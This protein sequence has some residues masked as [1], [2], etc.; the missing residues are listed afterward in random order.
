MMGVL[1][2]FGLA[3]ILWGVATERMARELLIFAALLAFFSFDEIVTGPR[4][5]R[6]ARS[7]R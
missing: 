5:Q 6:R 2:L 4:R 7:R 3:V 1:Y